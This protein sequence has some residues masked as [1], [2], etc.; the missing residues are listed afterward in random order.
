MSKPKTKKIAFASGGIIPKNVS[1]TG[2]DQVV[3]SHAE[4]AVPADYAD[5]LIHER[6]AYDPD[7]KAAPSKRAKANRANDVDQVI[8]DADER[9][10]AVIAAAETTAKEIIDAAEANATKVG[11]DAE[12]KAAE[13]VT[14]AET[15]AKEIIDAAEASA[16]NIVKAAEEKAKS[17]G[18]KDS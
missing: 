3:A 9:A 12:T 1:L 5:H 17:S 8:A 7:A 15:K 16:T 18:Q 10:K 11:E 4:V 2:K 6:V 13:T 14:L